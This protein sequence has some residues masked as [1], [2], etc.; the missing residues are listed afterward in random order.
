MSLKKIQ[1]QNAEVTSAKK[2]PV[3]HKI[4]SEHFIPINI[5]RFQWLL[6]QRLKILWQDHL[7][8][9]YVLMLPVYYVMVCEQIKESHRI[10]IFIHLLLQ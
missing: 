4:T 5:Y 3:L 6:Q 7:L 1:F 2:A 10:G 9:G 8:R